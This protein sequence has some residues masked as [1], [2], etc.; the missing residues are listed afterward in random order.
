M[1]MPPKGPCTEK[2]NGRGLVKAYPGTSLL[3]DAKINP[4]SY[5]GKLLNRAQNEH[6]ESSLHLCHPNV[7]QE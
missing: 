6:K 4:K 2:D 1:Q 3:V 5:G 7:S